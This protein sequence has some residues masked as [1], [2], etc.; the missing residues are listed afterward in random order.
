MNE[1]PKAQSLLKE[2][3][4]LTG[5][6]CADAEGSVTDQAGSFDADTFCAVGVVAGAQLESVGDVLAAGKLRRWYVV[7][8]AFTV[9]VTHR[10][11][12]LVVATGPAAKN[13]EPTSKALSRRQ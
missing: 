3:R 5:V 11:D 13:P 6:A 4:G 9:W 8:D 10:D 1:H 12:G 7:S 2:I